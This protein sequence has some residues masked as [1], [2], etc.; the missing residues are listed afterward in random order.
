MLFKKGAFPL[1]SVNQIIAKAGV[2][3][4]T[5]YLYFGSKEEIYLALLSQYFGEFGTS[6]VSRLLLSNR[7]D[8]IDNFSTEFLRFANDSPKAVYLASIVTLILENNIS[9]E[10][11]IGFKKSLIEIANQIGNAMADVTNGKNRQEYFKRFLLS[12]NQFLGMWQ[13]C[14]PPEHVKHLMGAQQL[15]ELLYDFDAE[16]KAQMK[17]TWADLI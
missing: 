11:L 1:P 5:V 15:D 6:F 13:H 14:N 2:A 16:F 10:Y 9:D 4:G 3:K 8:L 12:Y 17:R 7:D